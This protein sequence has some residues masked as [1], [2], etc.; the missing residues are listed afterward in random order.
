MP[1]APPRVCPKCRKAHSNPRGCPRC[2]PV[3]QGSSYGNSGTSRR[4]QAMR[5]NQLEA[6][7]FCQ[8]PGCRRLAVTAD[9]IVNIAAGGA[10][11]DPANYQSL[12]KPHHDAKTQTEAN[13]RRRGGP[14][15]PGP[16]PF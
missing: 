6:H 4:Q 12:C 3:W 7:P 13:A 1:T 16:A 15:D 11:Y 14:G 5:A 10:K 8:W 9:H 2:R